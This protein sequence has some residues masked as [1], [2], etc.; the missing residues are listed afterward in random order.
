MIASHSPLIRHLEVLWPWIIMHLQAFYPWIIRL[1]QSM[2][3]NHVG[4][5]TMEKDLTGF[6]QSF[7][8][9][10]WDRPSRLG[11][12]LRPSASEAGTLATSYLDN[13]RRICLFWS[14][15]VY[16]SCFM[17]AYLTR[18]CWYTYWENYRTTWLWLAH[19]SVGEEFP[20]ILC[21]GTSHHCIH[22][23]QMQQI[24]YRTLISLVL[25]TWI[26][27]GVLH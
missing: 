11:L 26:S 9:V 15:T 23:T 7:N 24:Y 18:W 14:A 25:T 12:N 4:V 19:N 17:S 21:T 5:N 22:L 8:K 27:L 3:V 13:L 10:T 16:F 6:F 2:C 1:L 20:G